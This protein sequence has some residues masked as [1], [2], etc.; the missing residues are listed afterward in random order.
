MEL[1]STATGHLKNTPLI[2]CNRVGERSWDRRQSWDTSWP[3]DDEP[4]RMKVL[5]LLVFDFDDGDEGEGEEERETRYVN[6]MKASRRGRFEIEG[7]R[8]GK[9]GWGRER[10]V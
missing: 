9:L 1:A 4:I 3:P 10:R 5:G 6:A 2:W 7:G 8:G